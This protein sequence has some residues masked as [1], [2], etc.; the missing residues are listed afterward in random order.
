MGAA[1]QLGGRYHLVFRGHHVLLGAALIFLLVW[2]TRART[3]LDV[4]ALGFALSVLTGMHT[5]AVMF[6]GAYPVNHFLVISLY[7]L[8]TYAIAQSRGGWLGDV[9]VT[10]MLA[11]AVLTLESG[12]L[13]VA[14]AAAGAIAGLRG[15]SRRGL[16]GMA[17]VLLLYVVLR[18]VVLDIQGAG[19]GGN[20]TGL[21]TTMLSPAEQLDRFSDNPLP[22]Y[23][24]NI[25]MSFLS[26]LLSQPKQGVWTVVAAWQ[27][28]RFDP[29]FV[30]EI[31]SS[32]LTTALIVWYASGRSKFGRRRWLEP[33]V[34]VFSV[35]LVANAGLS[36]NYA[37]N[38]IVSV[39]GVF[40]ALVAGA[41]LKE[42]LTSA[43][44]PPTNSVVTVVL[45]LLT[46]SWAIRDAGFHFKLRSA[47]FR[48]RSDWAFV[49]PTDYQSGATP[50]RLP[51]VVERIRSE[52]LLI[53]S[54]PPAQLPRW[55][56][57]WFR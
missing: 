8:A 16:A 47:A 55:G 46:L 14:I 1:E 34:F 10:L 15:I 56:D 3:W 17:I 24:Y 39:S 27:Q 23:A 25:T 53:S 20:A 30:V 42:L 57:D 33:P 37:T 11:A 36:L 28:G 38:E 51:A 7:A 29:V 54:P 52:A 26:V 6:V 4:V 41:A 19:L 48:T 45:L 43:P 12:L 18:V 2:M 31:G 32:I 44:R 35:L 21:G 9:T 50:D 22:L 49:Q 5:Y 40:Y 13:I